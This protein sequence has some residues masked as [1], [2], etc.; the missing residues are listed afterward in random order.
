MT[1]QAQLP[2]A[3][4]VFLDHVAWF[5]PETEAEGRA[6]GRLGFVLTPYV[7]HRAAT[8]DGGLELSGTANRC[9]MLQRGYLE[10]LSPV[11]GSE[12]ALASQLRDGLSRYAGVHLIAFSIADAEA[13]RSRLF[14]AGFDPRPVV[15]L[16]RL[17]AVDGG[18]DASAAFS[19]VRTPP[20]IMPEGRIQ[21]LV[22]ETPHLVWQPRHLA[23]EN[24]IE[25][26]TGILVAVADVAEAADRYARFTGRRA[27]EVGQ[28]CAVIALD[29][30]RIAFAP[31]NAARHDRRT[32]PAAPPFMA[33]VALQSS[34]LDRTRSFLASRRVRLV[35]QGANYLVVHPGDAAGT[36]LVIHAQ[37]ADEALHAR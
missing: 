7:Q 34:N 11:Q 33:A 16:R 10:I 9:A 19:V 24:A 29:R 4:E 5:A 3:G 31:W 12:T 8:A 27:E 26:L 1:S 32:A 2:Q 35:A 28:G 36:A 13:E 30:G 37:G 15:R 6:F 14:A 25:A 20:G 22:H 23:H 17:V 18:G 21:F